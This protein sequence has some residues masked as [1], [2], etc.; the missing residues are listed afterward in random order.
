[1]NHLRRLRLFR[2]L[3]V[4]TVLALVLSACAAPTA[5]PAAEAPA[6][7]A[8]AASDLPAEPGRGTDGTVTLVYWQ[9]ISILNS[10]LSQGTKDNHAA[11]LIIEPLMQF[12]PDG[13]LLPVLVT[14]CLLYTSPSPRDRTRSRMP[15]SA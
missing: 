4:L 11:S 14:D 5:A 15:S 7:E 1:M 12:A 9:E 8:P 13:S 3:G 10:Y 2:V 6:A